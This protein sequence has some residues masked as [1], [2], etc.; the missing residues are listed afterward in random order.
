MAGCEI[1]HISAISGD[2]HVSLSV[3][4]AY[5]VYG[6][7]SFRIVSCMV[8][9]LCGLEKRRCKGCL[10]QSL[11]PFGPV[12]ARIVSPRNALTASVARVARRFRPKA[13]ARLPAEQP[14]LW[15]VCVHHCP[16]YDR[17]RPEVNAHGFIECS[18][19]P[20]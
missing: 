4:P 2:F 15:R 9:M 5:R 13:I 6:S 10:D 7:V 20:D 14:L 8:H 17:A 1:A 18:P 3:V 19:Y 16:R 11:D 12:T